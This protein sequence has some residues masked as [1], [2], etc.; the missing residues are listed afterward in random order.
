MDRLKCWIV[1][2]LLLFA[3]LLQ[4]QVAWAEMLTVKGT[5]ND[6]YCVNDSTGKSMGCLN[7]N[8]EIELSP[9][10]YSVSL[11]GAKQTATVQA[12]QKTTL[13][14]GIATVKGT[15]NDGY[16]VN[17]STGQSMGCLN[18]NREIELFPGIQFLL[19]RC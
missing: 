14:A 19:T 4:G 10:T 6:G 12:G 5:G 13:V 9:G 16:C 7:T 2:I 15:G 8:R 18:T 17:D 1:S 3:L 11:H